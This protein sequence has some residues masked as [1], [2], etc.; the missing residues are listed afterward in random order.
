MLQKL[1]QMHGIRRRMWSESSVQQT[2]PQP[3]LVGSY[4]RQGDMQP[5][6]HFFP[7]WGQVSK[8][9]EKKLHSPGQQRIQ[10]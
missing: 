6:M 3:T 8:C 4:N 2:L 10:T 5:R 9:P 7:L 1:K